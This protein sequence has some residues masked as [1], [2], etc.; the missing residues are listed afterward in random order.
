MAYG[1]IVNVVVGKPG[2]QGRRIESR[3]ANGAPGMSIDFDIKLARKKQPSTATLQIHSP[4]DDTAAVFEDRTAYVRIELGY[5]DEGTFV[6]FTGNPTPGTAVFQKQG[7]NRVLSVQLQDGGL[8]YRVGRVEASFSEQVSAQ[9][10]FDEIIRQVGFPVGKTDLSTA[11]P[12]VRGWTFSGMARDALDDLAGHTGRG[13][14]LRDGA[15]YMLDPRNDT[16]ETAVVFSSDNGNLIGSPSGVG[17][18][19]EYTNTS[20]SKAFL[21]IG[22]DKTVETVKTTQTRGVEISGLPTAGV[23]T[24]RVFKVESRDYNGFYIA[25]EVSYKGSSYEGPFEVQ[26]VGVPRR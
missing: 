3:Q 23:K 16:G 18:D 21:G 7:A 1:R 13:W 4:S 22:E 2:T 24:G 17:V 19:V 6:A 11:L 26:I 25:K 9:E 12:L 10:V 5:V 8:R 20:T 14:F 15:I